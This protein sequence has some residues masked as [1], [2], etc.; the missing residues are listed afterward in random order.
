MMLT[1]KLFVC[2]LLCCLDS[3]LPS[4][5]QKRRFIMFSGLI[6]HCRFG[7]TVSRHIFHLRSPL[8]SDDDFP[9]GSGTSFA[10]TPF[11][12][13]H[14]AFL[15]PISSMLSPFSNTGRGRK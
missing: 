13:F 8:A 6:E 4:T 2:Y 15:N 3:N 11:A 1:M 14:S 10:I 5:F 9:W 12:P 7:S